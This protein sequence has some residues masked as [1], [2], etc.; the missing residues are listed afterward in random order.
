M[1]SDY[2]SINENDVIGVNIPPGSFLSTNIVASGAPGY[3]LRRFAGSDITVVDSTTLQTMAN[4][5][6]H[7]SAD[8]SKLFYYV[9]GD[10]FM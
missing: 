7:L 1:E 3:E 2:M 5:A 6:L 8:I 10:S 9:L 4:H